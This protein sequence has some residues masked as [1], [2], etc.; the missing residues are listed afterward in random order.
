MAI[1]TSGS[2]YAAGLF[3]GSNISGYW[4]NEIWTSQVSTLY[5]FQTQFIVIDH[6][7]NIFVGGFGYRQSDNYATPGYWKNGTWVSLSTNGSA[8]GAYAHSMTVDSVG[9]IYVGGYRWGYDG[10]IAGY[11]TN[12]TWTGLSTPTYTTYSEL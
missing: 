9:N 3:D 6:I 2:I 4:E 12:G 10:Q 7:L 1:D 8:N 5:I 11:W